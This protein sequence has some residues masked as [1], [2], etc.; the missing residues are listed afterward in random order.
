[1]YVCLFS[2]ESNDSSD[3]RTCNGQV[4]CPS[5]KLPA[6]TTHHIMNKNGIQESECATTTTV[7]SSLRL[8]PVQDAESSCIDSTDDEQSSDIGICI[9]VYM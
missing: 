8:S 9:Y 5:P 6:G 3:T 2:Q 7:A 4:L 1:M